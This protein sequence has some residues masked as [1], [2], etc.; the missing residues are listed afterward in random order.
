MEAA[1]NVVYPSPDLCLKTILS[2]RSTDNSFSLFPF[3]RLLARAWAVAWA[4]W[5]CQASAWRVMCSGVSG[6]WVHGWIC[7]GVDG[8]QRGLWSRRC[9]SLAVVVL[10]V[11][12]LGFP[13]SGGSLD[14]C[15]SD[16]LR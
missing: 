12:L 3:L 10:T 14:A 5:L 8:C 16:L 2:Q 1:E 9:S 15:G 13:C 11:V 6:L 7:S 4:P